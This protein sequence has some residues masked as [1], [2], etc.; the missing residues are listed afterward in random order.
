M[1]WLRSL[2]QAQGGPQQLVQ[3][4]SDKMGFMPLGIKWLYDFQKV[5]PESYRCWASSLTQRKPSSRRQQV[6]PLFSTHFQ[7][8]WGCGLSETRS[9]ETVVGGESL[10]STHAFLFHKEQGSVGRT[11]QVFSTEDLVGL[12]E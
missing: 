11:F 7:G 4:P 10:Y 6:A 8:S 9:R 12:N 3:V 5:Q 1:E 2:S